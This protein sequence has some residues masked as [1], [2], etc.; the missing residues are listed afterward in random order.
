MLELLDEVEQVVL[1]VLENEIDLALLLKCLL[2]AY[3]ILAFQHLQHFYFSLDGLLR[4]LILVALLKLL[5]CN[6]LPE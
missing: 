4:E 3:H 6:S 2:N 5:Y 1:K